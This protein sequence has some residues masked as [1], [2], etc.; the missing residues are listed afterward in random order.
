MLDRIFYQQKCKISTTTPNFSTSNNKDN[1]SNKSQPSS[2]SSKFPKKEFTSIKYTRPLRP[3]FPDLD[4]SELP[5]LSKID[6]LLDIFDASTGPIIDP[7]FPTTRPQVTIVSPETE[8]DDSDVLSAMTG[9]TPN[10]I[11]DLQ[12]KALVIKQVKNMTRKGRITTM[13]A[14]VVVGNGNGVAGYGEGKH[15]EAPTAI[16]KATNKAIKSLRYIERYDDRT[17]YHDIEH[18]FHGTRIKLWARPPGKISD[19]YL[20][21]YTITYTK[22]FDNK[23]INFQDSESGR[24]IMYMKFASVS[25]CKILHARFTDHVMG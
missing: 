10:E 25:V 22:F 18:K 16:K 20:S 3:R 21:I 5:D 23:R 8:S 12:K 1:K 13:Y 2:P 24:T 6:P 17:I 9:L 14:L 7:P 15:D 4:A 11:R 19:I